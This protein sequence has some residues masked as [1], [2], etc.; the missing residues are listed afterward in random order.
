NGEA[1]E[2]GD[3]G[4]GWVAARLRLDGPG[5]PVSLRSRLLEPRRENWRP[6]LL[7]P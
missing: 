3:G 6:V 4:A 2:T 5:E 1:R 7:L